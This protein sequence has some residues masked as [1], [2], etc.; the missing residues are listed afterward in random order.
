MARSLKEMLVTGY[1]SDLGNGRNVIVVDPGSMTVERTREFR[2]DLRD[3]AGGARIRVV[4]N[5]TARHALGPL[6]TGKEKAF[7]EVLAGPSAIVFGGDGMTSVAKVL[8]E[9]RRK[10][11]TLR[12]KGGVADGDVLDSKG[13]DALADLPG[14]PQLRGMIATAIAGP[15]RGLA[16]AIQ[17]LGAGLARCVQQRVE[18]GGGAAGEETTSGGGSAG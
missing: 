8:R 4:H 5:R 2:R 3:K 18:K 9:W 16:V 12:V 13:V 17:G 6:W 15:M 1:K 7:E 11:K 10:H 14:L